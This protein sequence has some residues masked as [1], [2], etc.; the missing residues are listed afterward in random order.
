[1]TGG[2]YLR[3]ITKLGLSKAEAGVFF[4]KTDRTSRTWATHGPSYRAA[5]VLRLMQAQGLSVDDVNEIMLSAKR[6]KRREA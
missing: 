6:R 2:E 1:M 5:M 3:A 4:G